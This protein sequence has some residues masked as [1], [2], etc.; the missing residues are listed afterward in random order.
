MWLQ[1]ALLAPV[2]FLVEVGFL[3]GPKSDLLPKLHWGSG[4]HCVP[5]WPALSMVPC[6]FCNLRCGRE[7]TVKIRS[8][9]HL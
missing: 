3:E 1:L 2:G 5:E 9:A 6:W 7:G 8:H 4:P